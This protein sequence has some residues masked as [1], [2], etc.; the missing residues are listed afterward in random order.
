[1]NLQLTRRTFAMG[2][3]GAAVVEASPTFTRLPRMRLVGLHAL[4][5]ELQKLLMA[6][7]HHPQ[8]RGPLRK[9]P[10]DVLLDIFFAGRFS[11]AIFLVNHIDGGLRTLAKLRMVAQ[12]F[13]C[14]KPLAS[15]P[16][17]S[18]FLRQF[19]ADLLGVTIMVAQA[20]RRSC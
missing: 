10:Q 19:G 3:L 7:E 8:R 6:I 17:A 18:H 4:I 20:A 1:M 16:A 2:A 9:T 11:L 12:H 15:A 5:V 13:L 14:A